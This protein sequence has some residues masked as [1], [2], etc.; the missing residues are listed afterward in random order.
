MKVVRVICCIFKLVRLFVITIVSFITCSRCSILCPA[1]GPPSCTAAEQVVQVRCSAHCSS[2]VHGRCSCR[3]HQL[4]A[5][6]SPPALLSEPEF[7]SP[8]LRYGT[9][10]RCIRPSFHREDPNLQ[11]ILSLGLHCALF[12]SPVFLAPYVR[13]KKCVRNRASA[14]QGLPAGS[15]FVVEVVVS[16]VAAVVGAASGRSSRISSGSAS[17]KEF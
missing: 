2:S 5:P 4:A 7:P 9:G 6:P 16:E 15:R 13:N 17:R 11:L 10:L 1:E 12:F 3:V 14:W 8:I